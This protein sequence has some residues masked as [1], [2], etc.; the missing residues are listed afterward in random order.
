MKPL[1]T[2]LAALLAL[3]SIPVHAGKVKS[4]LAFSEKSKDALVIVEAAPQKIVED[5]YVNVSSYSLDT[6]LFTSN[7]FKGHAL[8]QAV[9][10]Q[11][12]PRRY[13]VA[14]LKGAGTHVFYALGSQGYWGA[15]FDKGSRAYT[16]EPGKV[17]FL[18]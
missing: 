10:G 11:K 4:T 18:G 15:C 7:P 9:E 5:W 12:G 13:F 14:L 2:S 3:A 1:F 6:R 8:L 17:Y 16:F